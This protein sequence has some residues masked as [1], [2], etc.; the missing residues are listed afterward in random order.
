MPEY[1][2]TYAQQKWDNGKKILTAKDVLPIVEGQLKN[3]ETF[4]HKANKVLICDTDVLE[5]KVYCD[6]YYEA[7]PKAILDKIIAL[8]QYHFYFLTY[9][10]VPWEKDNL[11]DK[12]NEREKMFNLFQQ[13]LIEYSKPHLILKGNKETRLKTAIETID[14]LIL[15]TFKKE[16]QNKH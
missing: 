8:Q 6:V 3:E 9:I 15:R 12:P 10:D 11:R 2:R 13:A 14:K 16:K 5:T 1:S 4:T 7:Y